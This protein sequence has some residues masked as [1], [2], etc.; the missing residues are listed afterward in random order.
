MNVQGK[1]AIYISFLANVLRA[2]A[3]QFAVGYS[4]GRHL[5]EMESVSHAAVE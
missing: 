3:E 1:E 5:E 4:T 2:E